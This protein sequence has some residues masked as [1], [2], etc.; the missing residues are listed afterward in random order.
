MPLYFQYRK[1]RQCCEQVIRHYP[2]RGSHSGGGGV[3]IVHQ[4][5]ADKKDP[6]GFFESPESVFMDIK[7]YY[8]AFFIFFF[9]EKGFCNP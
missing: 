5:Q 4:D 7:W 9:R 1:N 8:R 3:C 2:K 6:S